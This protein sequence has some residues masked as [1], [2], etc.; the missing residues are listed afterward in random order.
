LELHLPEGV[1]PP[2]VD[3][4]VLRTLL[5]VIVSLRF[6]DCEQRRRLTRTIE[7]NGWSVRLGVDWVA[8]ARRGHDCAQATGD[9]PV[10]ALNDL[11]TNTRLA[12]LEGC[13]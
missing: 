4:D 11:Y 3:L 1:D 9:T 13:P 5:Q 8:E 2:E 7:Q 12:K 10:E 6:E